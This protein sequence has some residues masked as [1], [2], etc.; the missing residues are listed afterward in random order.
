[1]QIN[2]YFTYIP[3]YPISTAYLV[4]TKHNLVSQAQ[5]FEE[6]VLQ[7]PFN[8]HRFQKLYK[9]VKYLIKMHFYL[10]GFPYFPFQLRTQ[11]D[12]L[13]KALHLPAAVK[14]PATNDRLIMCN[15]MPSIC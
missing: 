8:W 13:H 6:R 3:N 4:M 7:L 5:Y 11:C 12:H 10:N 1:M 15:A 2:I 9:A 14:L